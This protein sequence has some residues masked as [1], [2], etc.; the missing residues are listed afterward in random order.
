M[1]RVTPNA[2]HWDDRGPNRASRRAAASKR[3]PI[4]QDLRSGGTFR[5]RVVRDRTVYTRK[6]RRQD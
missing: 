1:R 6:G 5:P 3:N 2:I 4:A